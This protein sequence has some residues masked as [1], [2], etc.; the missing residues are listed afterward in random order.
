MDV[1]FFGGNPSLEYHGYVKAPAEYRILLGQRIFTG[2]SS[3]AAN[4]E[5]VW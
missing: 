2:V 1:N 4:P 3:K 5:L